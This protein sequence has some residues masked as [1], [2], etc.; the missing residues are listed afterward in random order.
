MANFTYRIDRFMGI[1]QSRDESLISPSYSPDAMNMDASDGG[2]R[3]TKGF[4]KY[5]SVQIPTL[6]GAINRICFY[7]NASGSVPVA[8]T[9]TGIYTY[10]E[11]NETWN[12]RVS[13]EEERN[14]PC[15]SALMTRIG[16]TDTLLLAD[17]I[18]RVLKF[19]GSAFT[20]FGSAEGCSDIKVNCLAMFRNRLFAAGDAEHPDR[21]YYSKLPGGERSIE[22]WG[23]DPD[24]PS[25]EGG[26]IEIGAAGGD[27]ITALAAMSNQLLIFKKSSVWRLIG[28]RPGN[29]TVE[30]ISRD[31]SP[32]FGLAAAVYRDVIYF[33]T[34]EGLCSFNG[35]D[36]SPLPDARMI[37]GIMEKADV[38]DTRLAV[39]GD[40]LF[41]TVRVGLETRLI[42]YDPTLRR[43]MQ[44]GGFFAR[45]IV[46]D[47]GSLIIADSRR[48]LE[49]WGEGDD[50]DG[51]PINAYWTTPYTDL[52]DKSVIKSLRTLYLRGESYGDGRVVVGAEVGFTDETTGILLP[53]RVSEAAEVKLKNEGRVFRLRIANDLGGRFALTGGVELEMSVRK[54]TE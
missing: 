36:A 41:F 35:V 1:D 47:E 5:V 42:E 16:M 14:S 48:Y 49:K 54:R 29:F 3:V 17:G 19:D 38:T 43:Y 13:F 34:K 24:S 53:E 21:L 27:P 22:D 10:S 46:N 15:T 9:E 28:D 51:L 52:G 25:V 30:L 2:L 4:S 32:V 11:A 26:H 50:F 37:R 6:G 18:G 12:L 33:V 40:R 8:V 23:P 31:S 45:D 44:Y 20:E 7:K 39:A